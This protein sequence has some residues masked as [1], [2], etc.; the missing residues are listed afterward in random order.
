[1]NILPFDKRVP[2]VS[3]RVEGCSLRSTARIV[4]VSVN[5]VMKFVTDFGP[6]C[7]EYWP[8]PHSRLPRDPARR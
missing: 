2:I 1:M 7:E 4:A 6:V 8:Y 3:A 5:T